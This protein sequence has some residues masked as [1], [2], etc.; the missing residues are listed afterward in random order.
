MQV[1]F[2]LCIVLEDVVEPYQVNK[3]PF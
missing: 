3:L 1:I 2:L